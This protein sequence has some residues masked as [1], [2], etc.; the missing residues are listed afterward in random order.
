M[1]HEADVQVAEYPTCRMYDAAES[2]TSRSIKTTSTRL[3]EA[4]PGTRGGFSEIRRREPSSPSSSAP[5]VTL[6]TTVVERRASVQLGGS[7]SEKARIWTCGGTAAAWLHRCTFQPAERAW[8]GEPSCQVAVEWSRGAARRGAERWGTWFLACGW[9]GHAERHR[10]KDASKQGCQEQPRD[11]RRRACGI[12]ET[13]CKLRTETRPTHAQQVGRWAN[14]E[15]PWTETG[16]QMRHHEMRHPPGPAWCA[17]A[18]CVVLTAVR[19]T[20]LRRE[21]VGGGSPAHCSTR[22]Q[23][24]QPRSSKLAA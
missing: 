22:Q 19:R 3:H 15:W 20:G 9:V 4:T 18:W 2:A 12:T 10:A 11:V 7:P 1:E 14:S 23:T 6:W 21:G 5:G 24:R 13:A 16:A 17:P 8:I